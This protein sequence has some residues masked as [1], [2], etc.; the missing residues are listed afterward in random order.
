MSGRRQVQYHTST[1]EGRYGGGS[2]VVGSRAGGHPRCRLCGYLPAFDNQRYRS[3][4]AKALV[5]EQGMTHPRPDLTNGIK[6]HSFPRP[7][8]VTT[9]EESH[10]LLEVIHLMNDVFFIIK[11]KS[12]NSDINKAHN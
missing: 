6:R 1:T 8:C 3:V 10:A 9:S 5:K 11:G 7:E 12:N 2:G 4:L